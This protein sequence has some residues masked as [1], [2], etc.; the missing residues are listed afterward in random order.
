MSFSLKNLFKKKP[1]L[2]LMAE[3]LGNARLFYTTEGKGGN[4]RY[5]SDVAKFEMWWEFGGGKAV[6]VIDVPSEKYWES[7]TGLPL[8][9]R[10]KVLD[11]IGQRVAKD[12]VSSGK[13]RYE[14]GGGFL[15]IYGG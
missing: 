5:Q 11:F 14:L 6:A 10:D 2:D 13:G 12:Q 3:S 8:D 15:T 7:Q 4:V 1:E 9:Q